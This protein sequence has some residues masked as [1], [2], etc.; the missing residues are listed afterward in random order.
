MLRETPKIL[1][2]IFGLLGARGDDGAVERCIRAGG[3]ERASNRRP[4]E[5]DSGSFFRKGIAGDWRGVFTDRDRKI[6]EG[7]AGDQLVAM[8]YEV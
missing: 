7:L 5:E 2:R 8:G 1:R 4:G 6:Y 3:F